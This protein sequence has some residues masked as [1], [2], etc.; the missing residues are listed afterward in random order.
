MHWAPLAHGAPWPQHPALHEHQPGFLLPHLQCFC[1]VSQSILVKK[2]PK[3]YLAVILLA[4]FPTWWC[5]QLW[6]QS[7]PAL[8]GFKSFF[9]L[10]HSRSLKIDLSCLIQENNPVWR[11]LSFKRNPWNHGSESWALKLAAKLGNSHKTKR[12]YFSDVL[13]LPQERNKKGKRSPEFPV[14]PIAAVFSVP[15]EL[16]GGF[17]LAEFIVC[18]QAGSS[19][20]Q[21]HCL[22]LSQTE[23]ELLHILKFGPLQSFL[24][25]RAMAQPKAEM[26]FVCSADLPLRHCCHLSL[27][28]SW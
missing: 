5:C 10:I 4:A 27:F 26:S 11:M 12:F 20:V 17:D 7:A 16:G 19:G 9:G 14:F 23:A 1:R 22:S 13:S 24:L 15:M 3:S 18:N 8:D 25:W 6:A 28:C 21:C 2:W